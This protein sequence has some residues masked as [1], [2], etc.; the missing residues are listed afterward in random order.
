MF[1]QAA[2]HNRCA[3]SSASSGTALAAVLAGAILAVA[4]L[5][6]P[7]LAD[8]LPGAAVRADDVPAAALTARDAFYAQAYF[9]GSINASTGYDSEVADDVPSAFEGEML[10]SVTLYVAE[11]MGTSWVDPGGVVL[12]LYFSSCP[13]LLNPD[14]TYSYDWA[15]L[16]PQFVYSGVPGNMFIYSV[17]LT[18]PAQLE[19]PAALS[20]GATVLMDWGGSPPYCGFALANY[21]APA[22]CGELYW[23][24]L[25]SGAPRWTGMSEV[26]GFSA[27]LAYE[28]HAPQTGV[29]ETPLP[30]TWS[31]VKALYR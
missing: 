30:D 19:I 10:G 23:D 9:N 4:A 14:L 1:G 26:V 12:N 3:A 22:G 28:L 2:A 29:Q 15:D 27:D 7:T 25:E 24:N 13:P 17:E 5:A 31:S 11:W 18:L 8:A 16:D 20:I 6:S 21:G